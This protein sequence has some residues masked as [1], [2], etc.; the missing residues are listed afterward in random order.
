MNRV[1]LQY[2]MG[3]I[4]QCERLALHRLGSLTARDRDDADVAWGRQLL[5]AFREVC[6][7]DTNV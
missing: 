6:T 3:M 1:R 2:C 4:V 7:V 5:I